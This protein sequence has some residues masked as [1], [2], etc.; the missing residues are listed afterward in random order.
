MV[1]RLANAKLCTLD[2]ALRMSRDWI[3]YANEFL[4]AKEEAEEDE[5]REAE[6]KRPR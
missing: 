1:I 3:F 4:D 5:R 2:G 6:K